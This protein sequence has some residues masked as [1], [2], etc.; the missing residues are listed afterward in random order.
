MQLY[1]AD[2]FDLLP[3]LDADYVFTSPPYNRR[4][5]DVYENYRDTQADYFQFL[6][7]FVRTVRYRRW[8]FL[9]VQANYYNRVDVYRLIGEHAK[10]IQQIIVWEKTNPRPASGRQIT[11]AYEFF[12]VFGKEPLLSNCTYTKNVL[13]TAVNTSST[14][15]IHHA[16]MR[17]EV[18]DWFIQRFTTKGETVL[19]P[20]MGLGTTGIACKR[21]GR[22]FIGVELDPQYFALAEQRIASATPLATEGLPFDVS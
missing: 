18:A 11:N 22:E 1:N 9:N 2:C 5:D 3:T 15:K 17:Q 14:T 13:A 12:L 6:D 16:V 7:R 20:F 21:Y 4:R 10:S 19:D 8:M